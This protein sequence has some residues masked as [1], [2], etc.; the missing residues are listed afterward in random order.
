[1]RAGFAARPLPLPPGSRAMAGYG[2]MAQRGRPGD[3]TLQARALVLDDEA[4]GARVALVGLDLLS[5]SAALHEGVA[6]RLELFGPEEIVLAGTHTHTA[7]G[8]YFG[9]PFYDFFT[10]RPAILPRR[11]RFDGAWAAELCDAIA[12]AVRDALAGARPAAVGV[13]VAAAWGV[14]AN[15]SE[16]AFDANPEAE[17]WPPEAFGVGPPPPGL[18]PRQV[19]VDP[20]VVVVGA[21][22]P[23]LAEANQAIGLFATFGCHATALGVA[24][25]AYDRDWPGRAVDR[26]ASAL[27]RDCLALGLGGAGDASPLPPELLD[28]GDDPSSVQGAELADAR[29]AAVAAAIVRAASLAA[30]RAH[31]AELRTAMATWTPPSKVAQGGLPLIAG[32]EDA[33]SSLHP[34]IH[35]G[36]TRRRARAPHGTKW[37]LP[38]PRVFNRLCHAAPVHRLHRVHVG[39]HAFFTIPGE[40]TAAAG[41]RVGAALL[42]LEGTRSASPIGYANDYAGYF[43]TPEEY[44]L[45]H[46]EGAS[47][48]YGTL[49]IPSVVRDLLAPPAPVE[50]SPP[51]FVL[52]EDA[53]D[54]ALHALCAALDAGQALRLDD[55]DEGALQL[56]FAEGTTEPRVTLD[57]EP[58]EGAGLTL[59]GPR[60]EPVRWAVYLHPDLDESSAIELQVDGQS[61]PIVD[62]SADG[63][64]AALD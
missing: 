33:R 25:Q 19:K 53:L 11:W 45:Q 52:D 40:P 58:L 2:P 20:R 37:P 16:A 44:A 55:G 22:P 23:D 57:G 38:L 24:Q 15:R 63:G 47:T 39:D 50:S 64:A 43:T 51:S 9:N 18:A 1:M 36:M 12:A 26:V 60:G 28:S 8:R 59:E 62:S 17:C 13:G 32:A 4:R 48:M 35:E 61:R 41:A 7:P 5:G 29:G 6:A 3:D 21:F 46:Y 27:G 54:G 31:D 34:Q 49:T 30:E 42:A 10:I 14:A 56:L